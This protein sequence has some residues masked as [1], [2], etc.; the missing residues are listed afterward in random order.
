MITNLGEI[1]DG[2]FFPTTWINGE[3][4]VDVWQW[5]DSFGYTLATF[6]RTGGMAWEHESEA[7]YASEHEARAA[8]IADAE[9]RME[10][11]YPE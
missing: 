8:G 11:Q 1:P 4:A 10:W 2:S 3:M 9:Q 7:T 5:E 6:D